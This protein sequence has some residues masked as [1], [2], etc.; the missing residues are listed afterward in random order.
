MG[1]PALM[2]PPRRLRSWDLRKCVVREGSHQLTQDSAE[3]QA[4]L[5]SSNA[6]PLVSTNRE[7]TI[8]SVLSSSRHLCLT[9]SV[10]LFP[11]SSI[12]VLWYIVVHGPGSCSSRYLWLLYGKYLTFCWLRNSDLVFVYNQTHYSWLIRIKWYL[13]KIVHLTYVNGNCYTGFELL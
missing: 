7:I 5:G 4:G 12:F 3:G 10:I 9:D 2:W 8:Q 6:E 1:K 13:I 11:A